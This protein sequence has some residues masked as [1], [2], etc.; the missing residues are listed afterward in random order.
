[1]QHDARGHGSHTSFLRGFLDRE[2]LQLHILDESSLPLGQALQQPVEVV[3]Y[4]ALL[5]VVRRKKSFGI[6]ERYLNRAVP[7]TQMVDE[8]VTGQSVRPRSEGKRPVVAVALQMHRE[9]CL[10]DEV[11]DLG[12]GR[13]DAASEVST[14]VATEGFEELTVCSRVS[15]QAAS[16]QRPEALFGVLLQHWCS[17]RPRG[18]G[19]AILTRAVCKAQSGKSRVL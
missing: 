8:L 5:G 9:E 17:T 4:R 6:L 3:A 10:L 13:T 7:A 15:L 19:R 2:S 12:S 18:A 14:K 11:F 1:M 16:H